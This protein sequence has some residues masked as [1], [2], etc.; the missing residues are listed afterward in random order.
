MAAIAAC[1]FSLSPHP[2][3]ENRRASSHA[4]PKTK[5]SK[6]VKQ[7]NNG[8]IVA[9]AGGF[10]PLGDFG[11]RDA[12]PAE[13]ESNFGE[14]VVGNASTEHKI[15]IPTPA[16][17]SL[18]QKSCTPIS[19]SQPPMPKHQ[20]QQLMKKIVGWRFVEGEGGFRLQ[21]EWKVNHSE[22]GFELINRITKV[23]EAAGHY[24]LPF[25][26]HHQ[27]SNK[28]CAELWTDYIGGLSMNDFILAAKIDEIKISDLIPRKRVWA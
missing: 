21:C 18:A 2:N 17:L 23:A 1:R 24:P 14:K 13:I 28:V 27:D 7:W 26:N 5:N 10:D 12:F 16:A 4:K 22:A 8:S 19:P 25:L 20:A 11:A 3:P 15:L 6:S 9:K